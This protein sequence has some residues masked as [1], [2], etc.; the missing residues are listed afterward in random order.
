MQFADHLRDGFFPD[1]YVETS[2]NGNGAHVFLVVDKTEWSDPDYN[3]V[4][5]ELDAWLKGVL[6]AT[7]IELDTVEIKGHVATVSWKDGMPKH[8]MGTLAKLPRDWERFD[9]LKGSPDL[10]RPPVA[11]HDEGASDQGEGT[12]AEGREDAPGRQRPVPGSGTG[13][14][15]ASGLTMPSVFSLRR[16]MSVK[17]PATAWWS[18]ARTSESLA[19]CWSSSERG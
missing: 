18:R 8:M 7:G 14:D 17:A 1:C 10:H 9:E 12:C 11:R 13:Q 4:L 16:S 19:P 2:T 3:A 15:R 5:K 6:A